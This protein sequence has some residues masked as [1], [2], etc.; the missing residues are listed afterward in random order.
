MTPL[1]CHNELL[2]LE[3]RI[4][5]KTVTEPANTPLTATTRNITMCRGCYVKGEAS[6]TLRLLE[7]DA[8]VAQQ[9]RDLERQSRLPQIS[10]A[11]AE[12]TCKTCQDRG[13]NIRHEKGTIWGAIGADTMKLL[14]E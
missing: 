5:H 9:E 1:A 13:P 10:G 4:Q 11:R 12:G 3:S 8:P 14:Q 2:V 6:V 7:A